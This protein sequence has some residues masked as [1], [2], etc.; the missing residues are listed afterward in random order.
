MKIQNLRT[1]KFYNIATL[2]SMV[3]ASMASQSSSVVVDITNIV[4][5]CEGLHIF[6]ERSIRIRQLIA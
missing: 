4:S 1:K 3:T 2:A 6:T 5:G